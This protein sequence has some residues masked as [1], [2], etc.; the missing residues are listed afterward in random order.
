MTAPSGAAAPP[1]RTFA[2]LLSSSSASPPLLRPPERFKGMPAVSFLDEDVRSF[3]HKFRF[4]LIGKFA[5]SRPPMAEI[6]KA[7][8][9][10]GFGG[11]FSLGLLDQR[12]IL[13]NFDYEADFQRCWLRK[14]WSI[15]GAIM[16]VFKWTPDFRPEF[17][18]PIVPVWI[19]FEGL[20]AH[21]QDKRAIF[22][23]AN[24]IGSP[25]KVDSSTLLHNRPSVAR[26]C[27]ELDV[28]TDLTHQ[29]WINNGSFGG[30]TQKV[31]YEFVPPYCKECRKFGHTVA[32]CRAKT[33]NKRQEVRNEPGV[34]N[35]H[36]R[37]LIVPPRKRWRP[38][39][40]TIQEPPPSP[41]GR[42]PES[43]NSTTPLIIPDINPSLG[44]NT[45]DD[46]GVGHTSQTE[47]IPGHLSDGDELQ[48]ARPFSKSLLESWKEASKAFA[49]KLGTK[50]DNFVV[51]TK[52]KS[53]PRKDYSSQVPAVTTRLAAG[54][55]T[56][57]S[58]SH[59][60]K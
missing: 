30:F 37:S 15:K 49:S 52:K 11:A 9:L 46:Q 56:R 42:Q 13:M 18:S 20:P 19:A 44:I 57:V 2:D 21:L 47:S 32:D 50:Q 48:H 14:S 58:F 40:N 1:P 29:I 59:R 24:L 55:I 12:H 41:R 33:D 43:E 39:A 38:A 8:D 27:V 51:V 34:D 3:S 17:E 36:P 16:R 25:L 23:I 5:K 6:R 7:F 28:S 31:T 60:L 54:K 35:Q 22:S 53:R 26:V 45:I 4:A 10:I